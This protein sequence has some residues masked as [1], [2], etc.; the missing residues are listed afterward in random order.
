MTILT[1]WTV[2]C[3]I[4]IL[5][6]SRKK[7]LMLIFSQGAEQPNSLCLDAKQIVFLAMVLKIIDDRYN[8]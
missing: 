8:R 7:H 6:S 5:T 4:T 3:E 1:M 2:E